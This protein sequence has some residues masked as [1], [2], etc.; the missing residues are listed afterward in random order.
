MA[1]ALEIVD[2]GQN[3]R[4]AL[5]IADPVFSLNIFGLGFGDCGL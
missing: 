3:E 1:W 2:L 5:Q 4:L